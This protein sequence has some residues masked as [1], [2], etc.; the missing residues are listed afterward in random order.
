MNRFLNWTG[1]NDRSRRRLVSK[2]DVVMAWSVDRLGRSQIV[3]PVSIEDEA[4]SPFKENRLHDSPKNQI[5]E[6][7]PI[8]RPCVYRK[9][10]WGG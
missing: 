10:D 6:S 9:L 5:N 1:L 8:A 7:R 3:G 4:A 2:F